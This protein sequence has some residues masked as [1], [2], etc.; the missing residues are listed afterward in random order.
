[1]AA[2]GYSEIARPHPRLSAR[3]RLGVCGATL[4]PLFCTLLHPVMTA[5]LRVHDLDLPDTC[6][7]DH[8]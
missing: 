2:T 5:Q 4:S 7:L 3:D 6:V 1:M 8:V